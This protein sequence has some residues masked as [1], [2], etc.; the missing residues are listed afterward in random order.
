MAW[1]EKRQRQ[2]HVAHKVYWRDPSGK[3]RTRT[4]AR[5]TDA[6]RFARDVEHRKDRGDY[7]DPAAGN[8]TLAEM[9]DHYLSTA[10][11]RQTT[12][13]KYETLGRLYLADGIG[14]QPIRTITKADVR[15]L[16]A[17]LRK[18]KKGTATIEAVARLLHRVFEVA[19]DDDRMGRNPAHGVRV[20]PADRRPARFLTEAEVA[21]IADGVPARFRALVWI[22]ALGGLRI[23]EASAL[24]VRHLDL[25]AGTIRVEESSPEV[26]GRKITGRCSATTWTRTGTASLR[27]LTYSPDRR[28]G[29]SDRTRSASASSSP[30]P[31]E[32]GSSRPRRFTI[33]GTPPRHSWH[34]P[35]SR[36]WRRH[37]NSVTGRRR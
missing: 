23:G 35:A 6:Q 7:I 33:F 21:E 3:V 34:V 22:L 10:D 31:N 30:Q 2:H 14:Q 25:K 17:E 1:I 20:A 27:R 15:S 19:V 28:A 36:S 13:A 26:A 12:A 24:R 5:A 8:I 29:R 18:R 32:P 11:L 16:Y 4:F 9:V 37:L